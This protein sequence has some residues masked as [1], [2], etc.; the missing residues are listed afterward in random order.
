MV[1]KAQKSDRPQISH[2]IK[3]VVWSAP[4]RCVGSPGEVKARMHAGIY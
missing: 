3:A 4:S 1:I 2:V